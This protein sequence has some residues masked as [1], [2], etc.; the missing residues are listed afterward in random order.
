MRVVVH[1]NRNRPSKKVVN[2]V[3]LSQF[4]VPHPHTSNNKTGPNVS[5]HQRSEAFLMAMHLMF[6]LAGQFFSGTDGAVLFS[7]RQGS[8]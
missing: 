5:A 2:G 6:N 4:F 7:R 8:R 1:L 3:L